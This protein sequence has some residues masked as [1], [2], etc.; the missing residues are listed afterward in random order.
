MT[1]FDFASPLLTIKLACLIETPASPMLKPFRP[2][3]S[4]SRP[5]FVPDGF[6]KMDPELGTV[7]GCVFPRRLR[8]RSMVSSMSSRSPFISSSSAPTMTPPPGGK[9]VFSVFEDQP[10]SFDRLNSPI[11]RDSG[12]ASNQVAD[13]FAFRSGVHN[14]GTSQ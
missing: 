8:W 9:M 12:Y 1:S 13:F 7:K 4:M 14:Q 11:R 5:A 3:D 2:A 6:L 10:F